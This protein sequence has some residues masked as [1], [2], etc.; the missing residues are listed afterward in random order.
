MT[1]SLVTSTVSVALGAALVLGAQAPGFAAPGPS[2]SCKAAATLQKGASVSGKRLGTCIGKAFKAAGTMRSRTVYPGVLTGTTDY[3][4]GRTVDLTTRASDGGRVV[5]LGSGMW[6][7]E[8]SGTGW[9]RGLA[10][11]TPAQERAH[12]TL[13]EIRL[14]STPGAWKS[15]YS[16]F[17]ASWKA[18]GRTQRLDGVKV[19]EYR[20]VPR[21]GRDGV[22]QRIWIDAK[23]RVRLSHFSLSSGGETI[24]ARQRFSRFGKKVTI[25]APTV[26]TPSPM[27]TSTPVPTP[28]PVPVPNPSPEALTALGGSFVAA[29]AH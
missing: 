24:S 21:T 26:S 13:R 20:A 3:R 1:R 14:G 11:G 2:S 10:N 16:W 9:I 23:A 18:T 8:N 15:E 17:A 7:K 19:R 27:P 28:T 4:F 12:V 22:K 6:I 5:M 29:P 25:I